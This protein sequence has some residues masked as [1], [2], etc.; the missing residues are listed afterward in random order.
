VLKEQLTSERKLYRQIF[1]KAQDEFFVL[2]DKIKTE[3]KCNNCRAC[4]T[5]IYTNKTPSEI[6]DI[7]YSEDKNKA[8]WQVFS[9]DFVAHGY[10][11]L[12]LEEISAF[13][14]QQNHLSAARIN[15]DYVAKVLNFS[16]SAVFYRLKDSENYSNSQEKPPELKN[17]P[18][19]LLTFLHPDCAYNDW[20][21]AM[22][23]II[24][25]RISE[26]INKE[27]KR[28]QEHHKNFHCKRTGTC[29]RLA[30]AQY[31]Y[32]ELK[33]KASLGDS[34]AEQF[35]RVFVPYESI[36]AA[37]EKFPEYVD[38][39]MNEFIDTENIY[40]YYCTKI[41]DDN[42]CLI[43]ESEE[44]PRICADFPN[45]PLTILYPVCGYYPWKEEI[46]T[47][48]LLCHAMIEICSYSI[49]KLQNIRELQSYN[50]V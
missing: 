20:Q 12:S 8:F 21:D 40:F 37:R 11:T 47:S 3:I 39:V 6:I 32:E 10:E 5:L 26:D 13:N 31:S 22:D 19:K 49:E 4:H 7:C 2:A 50:T 28:I 16:E 36:E 48:A 38:F 43:Y 18:F 44:R 29:C 25:N 17:Y 30:S 23:Y 35:T 45:N 1:K 15:K 9:N 42:H 34:F 33:K 27:I 46:K 41:S 14:I 24:K